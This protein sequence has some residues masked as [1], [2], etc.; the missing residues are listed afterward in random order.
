MQGMIL[1]DHGQMIQ[2][3]LDEETIELHISCT[4]DG[5]LSTRKTSRSP[6]QLSCVLDITL[7]GPWELFEQIG[8]W[9][10]EYGVYLQDP[11]ECHLDVKYCNPHRLSSGD[12]SSCL[13]LSQV[14]SHTNISSYLQDITQGPD[15]LDI[16]S[17][18]VELEE[19]SQPR[20]IRAIL[21]R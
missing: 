2:G 6:A 19:T 14:M 9:F 7:Y 13:L 11:R 3:L 15:L 17:S 4:P 1:S 21:Q 12:L 8:I 20:A 5:E 18:N 16:L 10:Q